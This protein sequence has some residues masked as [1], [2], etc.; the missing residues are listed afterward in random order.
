[1]PRGL[2]LS[3]D[4]IVESIRGFARSAAGL[5]VGIGDDAALVR[6][7]GAAEYW[8]I[9]TDL[10]IE[11]IDFRLRWIA[12]ESLGHKA[13]ASN[14]SDLAAMGARPR[15]YTVSLGLTRRT[16][17]RWITRLYRGMVD[18][19]RRAGAELIGG[20]VSL[21]PA[22]IHI[23]IT[24]IGETRNRRYLLRS[25]GRPDDVVFVT[26]VL[27]GS[28]AGLLLL[29]SGRPPARSAAA[30]AALTAHRNPAPRCETGVWLAQSGL[31]TAM[32]DLSDG[33]STDL[34]RLCRASRTGAEIDASR[35]PLFEASSSWGGDPVGLALHG[36]EDFELLFTVPPNRVSRL[37]SRYP[38]RFPAI[39][40]IGRLTAAPS[41]RV[42]DGGDSRPWKLEP[43]GWD[44][45]RP[46]GGAT[47]KLPVSVPAVRRSARSSRA[48]RL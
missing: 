26:G 8:A 14:L 36:G 16:S 21:S 44:H 13:L 42:R 10:L 46:P 2:P 24:A 33:L 48:G 37:L 15:F 11:G 22:G 27:G 18:L 23:S 47:Q 9:T 28:A 45:L 5:K 40:P 1:M 34:S 7:R 17:S 25:G 39:T 29:E 4:S 3:E 30:L 31:C 20:D 12:P 41:L 6:P 38:H 19:G 35:L 32:M 43:L